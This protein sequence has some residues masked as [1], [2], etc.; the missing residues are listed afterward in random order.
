[1]RKGLKELTGRAMAFVKE[2][3]RPGVAFQDVPEVGLVLIKRRMERMRKVRRGEAETA[4][5][6]G[7]FVE[8]A[9][10]MGGP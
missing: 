6:P 3:P 10:V 2:V 7:E 1:M 5:P 9:Q 8:S 4:Q